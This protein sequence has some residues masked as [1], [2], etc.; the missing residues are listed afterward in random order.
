M[1]LCMIPVLVLLVPVG[2]VDFSKLFI[3]TE[4]MMCQCETGIFC[5]FVFVLVLASVVIVQY[6]LII[7]T[8]HCVTDAAP[9]N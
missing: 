6:V 5:F 3:W 9:I 7:L 4:K 2:I 8:L 1:A